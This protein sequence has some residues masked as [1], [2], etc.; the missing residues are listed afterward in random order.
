M[1]HKLVI[2]LI[3][4]AHGFIST[5][6]QDFEFH[7]LQ[8]YLYYDY[9]TAIG[10][11]D[12]D[13]MD[14][15]TSAIHLINRAKYQQMHGQVAAAERDLKRAAALSPFMVDL[16]F[17]E[18]RD[19]RRKLISVQPE[20]AMIT[21]DLARRLLFYSDYLEYYFAHN[22]IG[23]AYFLELTEVVDH[24]LRHDFERALSL[25]ALINDRNK[26][27]SVGQVL[28][29]IVLIENE[30]LAE[31]RTV[32]EEI[33]EAEPGLA[34]AWYNLSKIEAEEG[35]TEAAKTALENAIQL[36]SSFSKAHFDHAQFYGEM[37]DYEKAI[38]AYNKVLTQN[39]NLYIEALVN[40]GLAKK[41]LGD[42]SGALGDINL[43]MEIHPDEDIL[44]KNRGNL[45]LLEGKYKLAIE[46]Y[47]KA[48]ELN[49]NFP[50]ALHNKAIAHLLLYEFEQGCA[51]MQ[52]AA[53]LDYKP[54]MEKDAS[55]CHLIPR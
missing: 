37:G 40:R 24:L 49:R 1:L 32:L 43:A 30:K 15:P 22:Q 36:D 48:I 7:D 18:G 51:D 39:D 38:T 52:D 53:R 3:F 9:E 13:V 50:E 4:F 2:T 20:K 41:M 31:A 27:N 42:F 19:A 45:Y 16:Y 33:L 5:W 54:A 14:N 17:E 28:H 47:A 23:Y 11:L 12:H 29:A 25:S 55:F 44:F 34:H 8:H 46:D 10:Q 35:S 21:L 26:G 6:S